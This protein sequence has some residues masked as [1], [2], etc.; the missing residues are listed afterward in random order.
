MVIKFKN[1]SER[2]VLKF[3]I[4]RYK[5]LIIIMLNILLLSNKN[6]LLYDQ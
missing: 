2:R 5:K 4:L 6:G 1:S 3:G